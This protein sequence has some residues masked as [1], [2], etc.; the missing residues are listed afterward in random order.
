MPNWVDDDG[1]DHYEEYMRKQRRENPSKSKLTT[2]NNWD[3]LTYLLDGEKIDARLDY[4]AVVEWPDGSHKSIRVVSKREQQSTYDHGHTDT[5][6]D[7]RL[8]AVI[9]HHGFEVEVALE[10]LC[11]LQLVR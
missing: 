6:Y 5:F 3:R 7:H 10:K 8:Y 2:T 1:R 4:D 11:V 9:D